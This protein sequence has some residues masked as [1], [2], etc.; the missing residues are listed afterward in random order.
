MRASPA[1]WPMIST[2]EMSPW[3]LAITPVNWCRTPGPESA[4]TVTPN[5]SAIFVEPPPSHIV[6]QDV[7]DDRQEE[8]GRA[9]DDSRDPL[10]GPPQVLR[11][12][13]RGKR[14]PG[15]AEQQQEVEPDQPVV[16]AHDQ[17]EQPVMVDPHHSDG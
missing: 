6:P 7:E 12:E 3:R 15:D 17:R 10:V 14:D 11:Q 8:K 1:P 16:T 9:V 5:F 2:V 4:R 13:C